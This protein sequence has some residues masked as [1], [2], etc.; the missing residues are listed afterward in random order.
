MSSYI[1]ERFGELLFCSSSIGDVKAVTVDVIG[2]DY[3]S[4]GQREDSVAALDFDL[5]SVACCQ[6]RG[7][8]LG[9]VSGEF[10][11]LLAFPELEQSCAC[12]VAVE[13][14]SVGGYASDG[15]WIFVGESGKF[16]NLPFARPSL[17]DLRFEVLVGLPAAF[18][19]FN[20]THKLN[21]TG[22]MCCNSAASDS[23]VNSVAVPAGKI[24]TS[25]SVQRAR[26]SIWGLYRRK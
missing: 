22:Y 18:V 24:T 3:G 26:N 10:A 14:R 8:E 5:L 1:V 11:A 12:E 17:G 9:P 20:I 16:R 19:R 6:G 15:K 4:E 25:W 23:E 21:P 2:V 13:N 7:C